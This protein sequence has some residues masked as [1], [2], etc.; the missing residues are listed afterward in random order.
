MT[1]SEIHEAILI[2]REE[3]KQWQTPAVTIVSQREGDPFKVL[4][5]CIL[6]LRTQD[7]TTGPASQRLFARAG[8]PAAM[9]ALSEEEIV[10]AI[11]PVGFYRNKAKQIRELC[12]RLITDYGGKVPDEVDELLKLKGVGRKT[13][14][15]VVTLGFDKPGICVDT[16]VHRICNRWGYVRTKSP[17]ET[18]FALRERL[19]AEYWL[20]I[21]DLLVTFG[22]N[23]CH[24]VSPRCS[25]CRL[26]YLCERIGVVK[27]R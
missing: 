7:R 27:H 18:E 11:Y 10:E 21:N 25:T 3:V 15:L 12:G 14:N 19:P 22:Q 17:E 16:H 1:D 2:L 8:S 23:H 6:S 4:I 26:A 13:A 9:A 20:S 5:S 24:P